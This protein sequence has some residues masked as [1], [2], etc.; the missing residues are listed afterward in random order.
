[1][2]MSPSFMEIETE[3]QIYEYLFKKVEYS[4][5]QH[6][7][8]C[9]VHCSCWH[10]NQLKLTA[11]LNIYEISVVHPFQVHKSKE[12]KRTKNESQIKYKKINP[13]ITQP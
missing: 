7:R 12:K 5:T 6:G 4:F 10:R 8:S 9:I 3:K 11:S 2:R 1:M 13:Q